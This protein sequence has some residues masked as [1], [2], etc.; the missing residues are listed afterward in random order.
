[1]V[2]IHPHPNPTPSRG[3]QLNAGP[4]N[5]QSVIQKHVDSGVSLPG[6]GPLRIAVEIRQPDAGSAKPVALVCLPG[7]AMNRRFY[8][9][10]ATDGSADAMSFS[11]ARQMAARGFTVVMLDYLGL[12]GSDKP[13][14]GYALTPEL[15]TQANAN[16]TEAVLSELR[17]QQPGL[18]TVGVGHSMGA[19]M[20][21]LQQA[22]HHPHAA[23]ALLGFS[24]R[25][26][27][28]YLS[29]E[30]RALAAQ[31]T[32]AVR[33]QVVALAQQFF[34][35]P[36][37]VIKGGAESSNLYAGAKADPRAGAVIKPASEPLLP[38]P[39][40]M[41]M[42]PGNVA[43]EA[44]RVDVPVFLGVGELDIAGPPQDIPAAF[45][46][47]PA[48]SLNIWPGTG[49]SHFLFASRQQ[50]FETL[51]AWIDEVV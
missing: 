10:Y 25:G 49:H 23:L 2:V 27:P 20:T 48:V 11:F 33:A 1:M 22:H 41:S 8:D 9:L 32:E 35:A 4:G 31:G 34:K 5:V 28:E 46:A 18:K 7:G 43:P 36:Y 37:P 14:D 12:G 44:A 38:V 39:A 51:A 6:E 40:F 29:P 26:L 19:M 42:L 15:L 50:Q 17:A 24:T 3:R 47:S 30:A 13:A 45:P 16:A 21:V